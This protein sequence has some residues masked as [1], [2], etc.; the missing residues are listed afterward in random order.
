MRTPKEYL[1]NLQRK[2]IT[3]AMLFDC[4]FSSNKRAKNWRDKQREYSERRMSSRHFHDKYNNEG[5]IGK[6]I[7]C[8]LSSSLL[9]SIVFSE[10]MSVAGFMIMKKRIGN[11]KEKDFSYGKIVSITSAEYPDHR[12]AYGR[13]FCTIAS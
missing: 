3:T 7:Y 13:G 11:L 8:F 6:K 5:I 2:L 1:D 9:V 4:I 10:A 12:F